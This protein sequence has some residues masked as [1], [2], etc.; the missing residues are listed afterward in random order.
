MK[1]RLQSLM[2][3]LVLLCPPIAAQTPNVQLPRA[4]LEKAGVS[5]GISLLPEGLVV[6]TPN[7]IWSAPWNLIESYQPSDG[8]VALLSS[9]DTREWNKLPL[10]AYTSKDQ[11]EISRGVSRAAGIKGSPPE[12]VT[13]FLPAEKTASVTL[14][15]SALSRIPQGKSLALLPEGLAIRT[16]TRL[17]SL[18]WDQIE[19]M[20]TIRKGKMVGL[21]VNA[22][23][24]YS[25][26]AF[27]L[28]S[29]PG[30]GLVLSVKE[31]ATL[32]QVVVKAAP[33]KKER[34]TLEEG[35]TVNVYS[36]HGKAKPS[37]P[38]QDI[39]YKITY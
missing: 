35:F 37:R 7:E 20:R 25:L 5:V 9:V 16:A 34:G 1:S 30:Q 13:T 26:P 27:I 23:P 8:Q 6:V 38:V 21:M 14:E 24:K 4:S 33:L 32:E 18:R 2:I 31:L 3:L 15:L 22:S 17:R 29:M 39:L 36:G 10:F 11:A 19:Y 28:T 12:R